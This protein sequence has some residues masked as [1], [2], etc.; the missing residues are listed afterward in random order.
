MSGYLRRVLMRT[1]GAPL[2]A[3]KPAAPHRWS[4]AADPFAAAEQA[5]GQGATPAPAAPQDSSTYSSA[6][7]ATVP[8]PILRPRAD[9]PVGGRR[10]SREAGDGRTRDEQRSQLIARVDERSQSTAVPFRR[11]ES[12]G[13]ERHVVVP[14]ARRDARDVPHVAMPPV[15]AVASIPAREQASTRRD[16]PARSDSN[17][18]NEVRTL[19]PAIQAA[20]RAAEPPSR[21]DAPTMFQPRSAPMVLAAPPSAPAPATPPGADVVIG[22]VTVVVESTPAKPR[23]PAVQRVVHRAAATAKAPSDTASFSHRFG[24]GQL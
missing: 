6:P 14:S 18:A 15:Q 8:P 10:T 20:V 16:E 17:S 4:L 2:Q 12:I 11:S 7:V 3:L 24:L 5:F 1:A 19:T 9:T 13:A 23:P 22:R 21:T